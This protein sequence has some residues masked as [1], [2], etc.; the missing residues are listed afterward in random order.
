MARRA[1]WADRL[2]DDSLTNG[3]Q[4]I[5]DLMPSLDIDER[6][7]ITVVRQIIDLTLTP[8]P[9]S[10]V[11]GTMRADF[12]IG[13]VSVDAQV[14]GAV[15]EPSVQTDRPSQGWLWRWRGVVLDD[16]TQ[17]PINTRVMADLRAKRRVSSGVLV[18]IA[19]GTAISGTAFV[20]NVTGIIRTLFLLP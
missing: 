7:N 3:A 6:T 14:A 5:F 20:V 9:T 13:L 16:T 4:L 2:M 15:P 17:V 18:M 10:G 11:V 8:E 12:G 1:A 19:D